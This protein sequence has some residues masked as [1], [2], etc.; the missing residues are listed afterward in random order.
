MLCSG[1]QAD[2]QVA[3]RGGPPRYE[4]VCLGTV[5]RTHTEHRGG[6]VEKLLTV[7]AIGPA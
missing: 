3:Q 5:N 6:L 1:T 2:G 4:S 7:D